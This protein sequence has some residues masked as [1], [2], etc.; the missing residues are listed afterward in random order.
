MIM[1]SRF[2]R[3]LIDIFITYRDFMVSRCEL[4]SNVPDTILT[5]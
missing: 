3:Y 2:R 5:F 1:T 4:N